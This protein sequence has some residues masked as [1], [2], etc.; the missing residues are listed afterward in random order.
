MTKRYAD[1]SAMYDDAKE[2]PTP[3]NT[4]TLDTTSTTHSIPDLDSETAIGYSENTN[5]QMDLA[6]L[7]DHFQQL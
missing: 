7:Q 2:I 5:P 3:N 6:L 1:Q 4:A